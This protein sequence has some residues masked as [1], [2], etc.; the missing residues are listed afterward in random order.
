MVRQAR[1]EK[2]NDFF[3]PLSARREKGVFFCRIAGCSDEVTAFLLRYF[4][5]ARRTGVI[6]DGR[7]PNPT[8]D[9]L[10]YFTEMM[11]TEFRRDAA[12][13]SEKL[14]RWLP[15]MSQQQRDAV[16]AAM[17]STFQD[18]L[19]SGK[20]ENMLRN[21]YTK[22]MCWLYY[23]F[24]R[25]VNRLGAEEP[26]KILYDGTVSQY[27]LLLLTVLSR[28]GADIVLLER[29]GDGGYA[30]L[31]PQSAWSQ[32]YQAGGLGQFPPDFGVKWLQTRLAQ[33]ADRQRLYGTPPSVRGCTNAWMHEA[34]LGQ[35]LTGAQARGGERDVFYNC[36]IAQ[37]GAE[38]RLTYPRELFAFHQQLKSGRRVCVVS[39][40]IP[41]PTPEEIA[42]I[43]RRNYTDP[44][45]LAA[46]L[47][48]NLQYSANAELQRLMVKSFLDIVLEEGE[49]LA[50]NLPKLTNRAVYLLC[51]LKRYQGT[52]FSGWKLPEVSVFIL[53]GGC[54]TEAEALFLRMLARLPVDVLLLSPDL[55]AGSCLQD[56]VLLELRRSESVRM[57][58]FPE[59]RG[60]G[61]VST[62]AY[63]AERELDT[64]LY[65]DS[66]LYRDRQYAKAETVT[67]QT[68]YEEIA[69]LWDQ[70]L[71]YRPSFSVV[72]RTVTM[73][74]LLE[75]ICGVKDGQTA[76][77]W[78][79]IKKL[80][81]PDTRVISKVPWL[82]SLSPSPIKPYAT[83]LLR[84]GK[85]LRDKIKGHSAYGY[86][87]L[88]AEIQDHLL[89]KI[90]L[91]LDRRT[92]A[93]TYEN[94]TEYT[95]LS[96]ALS[97]P[98]DILRMIQRFDFTKKNPKLIFIDTTE[99]ILSLEDSIAAAFLNLVG[100]DILFF[101]PTGYQ[102][103]ERYFRE[104]FANEHQI[105]EYLYDLSVP[106][107]RTLQ[108]GGSSP[109]RKLFG[110]SNQ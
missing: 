64:L 13:L 75:K 84:N 93:G 60:Q 42:G 17:D 108:E 102:C 54:A 59:E 38:D 77:Y 109:F 101:V 70:E 95:V 31:D 100:F 56:P 32:C 45:Q 86:G 87:I 23:R 79:E 11:G 106:D 27:E 73:P 110:R 90:Q 9:N 80:I 40:G 52:L 18:L 26:P 78:Q 12:F 1:L 62:A 72:D 16:A 49:T 43:R 8:P 57:D 37:Y 14:R 68:M 3:S 91:L 61:R 39:G 99:K 33:E 2:L 36:F 6:I 41:A 82:T 22:Y 20:N 85:L 34:S 88:R 76:A 67:L 63:Q 83:Q 94:G 25:I 35:V 74:V 24:E 5:A 65:Q 10:A 51:W 98:K 15:R 92:I 28:A 50:G 103:I 47:A 7:I 97:L 69:I 48:R 21:A 89:D 96:T 30:A 105:G 44:Q 46:D 29:E 4:D 58:S 107:L 71:K 53:F 19:R 104:P 55:D 81:T 66:G